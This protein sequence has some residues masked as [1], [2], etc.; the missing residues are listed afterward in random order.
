MLSKRKG[1]GALRPINHS[2]EISREKFPSAFVSQ[3]TAAFIRL[4]A[5][6]PRLDHHWR[7]ARSGQQTRASG[8]VTAAAAHRGQ[9]TSWNKPPPDSSVCPFGHLRVAPPKQP[10]LLTARVRF[11]TFPEPKT[12]N[13]RQTR[14]PVTNDISSALLPKAS[15][16][17]NG[18]LR[19]R[20]S[21]PGLT[22]SLK[23][24]AGYKFS[25]K[26]GRY[27]RP[28]KILFTNTRLKRLTRW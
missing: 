11:S 17:R 19:P 10:S 13:R 14:S 15:E 3:A 24:T 23:V 5:P 2:Y 4:A 18:R 26:L 12:R 1:Q 21:A 16:C 22:R 20:A 8:S 25:H 28:V 6:G 7:V 9:R 27:Q